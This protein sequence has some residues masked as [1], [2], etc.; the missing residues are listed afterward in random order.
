MTSMKEL[1]LVQE[2]PP[3]PI[4]RKGPQTLKQEKIDYI[5]DHVAVG[6]WIRFATYSHQSTS[7]KAKSDLDELLDANWE[8]TTRTVREGNSTFY[9]VY[10]R[11]LGGGS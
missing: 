11:Y 9:R 6:V 4:R 1:G 7:S 10:V 5:R 3:E 8:T 2:T